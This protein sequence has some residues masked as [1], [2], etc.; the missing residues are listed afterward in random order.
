MI[1]TKP[2]RYQRLQS[3]HP[4]LIAALEALGDA[5]QS[6]G[7]LD[8]RI[9]HLLQVAVGAAIHSEGAVHSHARRALAAGATPEELRHA[10][11]SLVNTLGFPTVSA[12]LSW[13]DDVLDSH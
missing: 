13:V 5:A 12:A 4:Q 6:A 2:P 9:T 3:E 10:V 11:L 1:T 7:P 8:P